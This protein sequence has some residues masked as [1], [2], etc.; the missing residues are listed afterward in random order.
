MSYEH[1]I[2]WRARVDTVRRERPTVTRLRRRA[3]RLA[4]RCATLAL[5][6]AAFAAGAILMLVLLQE[7]LRS[8]LSTT[9]VVP[10]SHA[11]GK[12]L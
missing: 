6:G 4:K 7:A 10:E 12:V 9:P 11:P 2:N 5:Y 1:L 3:V 8:P